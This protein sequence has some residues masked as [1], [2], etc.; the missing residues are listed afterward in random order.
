MTQQLPEAVPVFAALGDPVRFAIVARLCDDG[1]LPTIVLKQGTEL[2]RQAITKHL[3]VLEQAGILR[4]DR[5]GRDRAWG[6]DGQALAMTSDTLAR[7]SALWDARLE[8]LR[9][10]VERDE[11]DDRSR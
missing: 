7:I 1:P 3:R 9:A 10:L 2:S 5:M 8:R 4:S 11:V 6:I